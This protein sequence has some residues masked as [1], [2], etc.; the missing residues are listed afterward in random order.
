M[1]RPKKATRELIS[2]DEAEAAMYR[3]LIATLEREKKEAARDM[4][5]A[6]AQKM[7]EKCI[8]EHIRE[9]ADCEAQLQNYYLT[10]IAEIEVDGARSLKLGYGTIGRRTSPAA[11]KLLNKSWNWAAVKVKL[12]ALFGATYFHVPAAPEIDKDRVKAELDEHRLRECGLQ[13]H[14]DEKFYAEVQRP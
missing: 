5:V 7:F 12:R 9:Q 3:L 14:Q 1:A 2:R 8:D 4:Q 11:L 10:H 13:L 6:A